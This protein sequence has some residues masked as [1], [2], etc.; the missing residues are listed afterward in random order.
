MLRALRTQVREANLKV[1]ASDK[2]KS[3]GSLSLPSLKLQDL[4]Q[5]QAPILRLAFKKALE[6]D[7][8]P[9]EIPQGTPGSL[10]PAFRMS[11]VATEGT[12]RVGTGS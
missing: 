3:V 11:G 7:D 10:A 1:D 8:T 6:A 2:S 9:R 4:L 5:F 12:E